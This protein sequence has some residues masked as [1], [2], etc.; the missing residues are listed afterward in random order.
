MSKTARILTVFV[1]S[2]G[3]VAEERAVLINVVDSINRIDGKPHGFRLELFQWEDDV[4]PQV[5]PGPQPT[6]DA[7]TPVYDI[8]VGIMSTRFGTPT[9]EYGSGTEKEFKDALKQWKQVGS[10]WIT[11]Y[12]DDAPSL[13]SKPDDAIQYVRVC[14]FREKLQSQGIVCGY[15]GVRG[16]DDS[17]YEKVY[18][19]LR[20][21]AHRLAPP[22][23]DR[24]PPRPPADA[25][26]YLRS[27]S[28]R[29][30]HIDI[31]GLLIGSGKAP[32]FPIDELY[33]PL[34]TT[35][36]DRG[37][38]EGKRAK[39]RV[40]EL[41]AC[42]TVRTELH[43]ALASRRLVIVGDPGSG[44][45]TFLRRIAYLLCRMHLGE[46]S[47]AVRR[48]LG[49]ADHPFPMLISLA[50]LGQYVSRL[51]DHNTGPIA[52]DAPAWLPRYLATAAEENHA[53]LTAAFF[54]SQLESGS[55]IVLLDG[56][57]E[58]PSRENR[59]LLSALVENAAKTFFGCRFVVTSR[60]TAYRDDVLLTDF[61]QVQ[62]D[63][64]EDE[65]IETF[66]RRWCEALFADSPGEV[67]RHLEELLTAL[68]ARPEIR[69]LAR[70]PVMLTALAVVHWNE[71][72]IP[73]QRAD[74]Y[75]SIIG[76]LA[77]AR[78]GGPS[79]P[80]PDRCVLLHQELALAMQ[81]REQGRQV[82]ITHFD[83]AEAIADAWEGDRQAAESF[84]RD[85]ELDS[86]I[87]VSRGDPRFADRA[88]EAN[89]IEIPAGE[90]WMG[91][92]K[93]DASQRNYDPAEWGDESPVHRV[94]LDA[95]R[96]GRYPVT[97][98]EYRHFVEQGGYGDEQ[99]WQAGGFQQWQAP[100][101]WEEQLQYPNR[102]VVYVSWYEASAYAAWC[103][104]RLPTEAEWERAA[105]GTEGRKYPWGNEDPNPSLLNY[106][107]NIGRA[108]PVGVYPRGA[109]PEGILDMAGNV[110]EWCQDWFGDYPAGRVSNP[111][112]PRGSNCWKANVEPGSREKELSDDPTKETI[113]EIR[114]PPSSRNNHGYDARLRTG[115]RIPS[116]PDRRVSGVQLRSDR[117]RYRAMDA[118]DPGLAAGASL[119][120]PR[121]RHGEVPGFGNDRGDCPVLATDET[122]QPLGYRRQPDPGWDCPGCPRQ[123][124]LRLPRREISPRT[125]QRADLC[126][127]RKGPQRHLRTT[128]I[129]L[130]R[131]GLEPGNPGP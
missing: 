22:D 130:G 6:V 129:Q 50:D 24:T 112:G 89:W 82:Q 63:A 66:L 105:R 67:G 97:V 33:I 114:C 1:S 131:R 18:E 13:S 126:P 20:K 15:T 48:K 14:Q 17:F 5:G 2:P 91:T 37:R 42:G 86:G 77:R 99:Y 113:H 65:A 47:D 94:Y 9:D 84:L 69:R 70:N 108:T 56:L 51:R 8:Y 31:R 111:S 87:V 110:W 39:N 127:Q 96:I 76:W 107:S 36:H 40:R 73:E 92:Q 88:R 43:E 7:Q 54:E 109:T 16:S 118:G 26:T 61:A 59:Q 125:G 81:D 104:V 93:V 119:G 79:R 101:N 123:R 115:I 29:T 78:K 128:A 103:G 116:C 38:G 100:D 49:L 124:V 4:V 98:G 35:G 57:D 3:D 44:K 75:E 58:A 28:E 71:K 74:L 12:F 62:I 30:S 34:T 21:I 83:A 11:F 32:R 85:E 117:R 120:S 23:S 106:Q 53:G 90:F 27:L 121:R 64:L 55:A 102:P 68:H 25:K 10:P 41:E 60:P 46:D 45:T 95:Y 52:L 80:S 72:R 19:H 122:A